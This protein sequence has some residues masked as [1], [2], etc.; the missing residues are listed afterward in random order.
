MNAVTNSKYIT[1]IIINKRNDKYLQEENSSI[2]HFTSI[3]LSLVPKEDIRLRSV[4][5]HLITFLK[6]WYIKVV[7]PF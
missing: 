4:L 1:L 3:D 6:S 5:V 2:H 7:Y